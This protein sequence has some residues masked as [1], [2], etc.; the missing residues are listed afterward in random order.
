VPKLDCR[1]TEAYFRPLLPTCES[2]EWTTTSKEYIKMGSE[3]KSPTV[4]VTG[5]GNTN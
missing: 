4:K 1:E 5:I 3:K 2:I